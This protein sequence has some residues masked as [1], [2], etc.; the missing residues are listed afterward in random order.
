MNFSVFFRV[1]PWQNQLGHGFNA[2]ALNLGQII[3]HPP[4]CTRLPIIVIVQ[5]IDEINGFFM[6]LIMMIF[7]NIYSNIFTFFKYV[8]YNPQKQSVESANPL[9]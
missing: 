6:G 4:L 9:Y 7:M 1:F 3:P 2:N 8:L 5:R